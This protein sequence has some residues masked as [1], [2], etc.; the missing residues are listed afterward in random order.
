[1]VLL[2]FKFT[3][4]DHIFQHTPLEQLDR[5][6]FAKGSSVSNVPSNGN[7]SKDDLKKEIAL[8]EVKMRR[9]CEILDEVSCS[10]LFVRNDMCSKILTIGKLSMIMPV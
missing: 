4:N 10:F 8:I 7:S 9:L 2:I 1:M 5:K 6:H 3:V